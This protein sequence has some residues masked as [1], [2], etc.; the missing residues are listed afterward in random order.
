M[1]FNAI[2]AL[3]AVTKAITALGG[4]AAAT[5]T[6][7]GTAA[8]IGT[9]G[10]IST[11]LTVGSGIIGAY[12]QY[13]NARA[14][15]RVAEQN[16]AAQEEAARES[17]TIGERESDRQRR[18]GAI[19]NSRIR[20]QL[21]ANGIDPGSD[22][23]LDFLD[24][25]RELIEEDAFTIRTNALSQAQNQTRAASNFRADAA[26]ARSNAFFQP[27][28]TVLTTGARVGAKYSQWAADREARAY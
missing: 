21:A 6:A 19:S 26:T 18:A 16:A 15:E 22:A 4:T 23:A 11:A 8:G 13:V 14:Q 12:G 24:E 7:A 17:I 1:C 25:Q 27:L 2:M 3:P 20:A 9:A 5:G 28:G 10:G